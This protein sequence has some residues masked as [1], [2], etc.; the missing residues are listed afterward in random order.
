LALIGGITAWV[1][2]RRSWP[3][4]REQLSLALWAGWALCYGIV[5]SAAGGLFH[6]YYVVTLAPAVS[7]LAGIGTIALWWLYAA[8]GVMALLAPI[9]LIATALWQGYIAE[10]YL[11]GSLAIGEK[12]LV[13]ALVGATGLSTAGLLS[14]RRHQRM[15]AMVL[16]G[17]ALSILLVMPAAWSVGTVQAKGNTGFPSARP[18]F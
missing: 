11:A 8:D 18:P 7:A 15:P 14:F 12:W 13:P 6:A 1:H 4:G 9:T 16:G 5:F 3:P 17:L 2:V 10:A